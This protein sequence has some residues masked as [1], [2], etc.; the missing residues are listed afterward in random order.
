MGTRIPNGSQKDRFA[1]LHAR[2]GP[3]KQVS[4]EYLDTYSVKELLRNKRRNAGG[5]WCAVGLIKGQILKN[6]ERN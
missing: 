6:G 5:W 4:V 1:I 2:S 3:T